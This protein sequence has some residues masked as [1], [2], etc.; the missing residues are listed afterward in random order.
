MPTIN[1]AMGETDDAPPL[2][3]YLIRHGETALNAQGRLRGWSNPA[4]NAEGLEDAKE[5][6]E[7][8]A[9]IPLD[10]IFVSDLLRAVETA[11][12]VDKAQ[13]H[14][15]KV[16]VTDDLR[17]INW[18]TF[19]GKLL[20][21]VEPKMVAIQ[22]RWKTEPDFPAPAGETWNEFQ[23]RQLRVWG[24]IL[25]MQGHVALVAHLR[26]CIWGMVYALNNG[27]PIHGQAI[28]LLDRVTQQEGR[29]TV[30]T[31]SRK[32]GF[33]ILAASTVAPVQ[34]ETAPK[35]LPKPKS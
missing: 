24:K 19:N 5:A 2:T 17:P 20:T 27:K 21:E 11:E 7:A 8:M 34:S 29:V 22:K 10:H 16:T 18:G 6:G 12:A 31:Y 23:E 1:Q 26:N 3:V 35:M 9:D 25:K 32:D 13:P 14:P 30:I 28:D 15:C 33:K 4:L